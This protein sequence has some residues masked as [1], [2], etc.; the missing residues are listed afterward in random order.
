MPPG[1]PAARA[2]RTPAPPL[3]AA[4]PPAHVPAAPGRR[5]SVDPDQGFGGRRTL[6]PGGTPPGH[7]TYGEPLSS[8]R[9]AALAA[10]ETV[11]Q[12]VVVD[13]VPAPRAEAARA[14]PAQS[15]GRGV[16]VV[17]VIMILMAILFGVGMALAG[18]MVALGG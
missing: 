17:V 10:A 13:P 5:R 4:V 9:L 2:T 3:G 15:R 11:V 12:H 16:R 7:T 8:S 18:A 14:E 6:R 1:S